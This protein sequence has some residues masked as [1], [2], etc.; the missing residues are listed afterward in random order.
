[1]IWT[2]EAIGDAPHDRSRHPERADEGLSPAE[3]AVETLHLPSRAAKVLALERYWTPGCTAR[4]L[5]RADE[6]VER[7]IHADAEPSDPDGTLE[8]ARIGTRLAQLLPS[9]PERRQLLVRSLAILASA[10]HARGLRLEARASVRSALEIAARTR[11]DPCILGDLQRR[12]SVLL[13]AF[14]R[15]DD[16]LAAADQAVR[17]VEAEAPACR[18]MDWSH[19]LGRVLLDR[20]RLRLRLH[21]AAEALDDAGLALEALDPARHGAEVERCLDLLSL[22]LESSGRPELLHGLGRRLG[23][24]RERIDRG[25]PALRP[26]SARVH[27]LEGRLFLRTGSKSRAERSLRHARREVRSLGRRRGLLVVSLELARLLARDERREELRR[28]SRDT[29]GHFEGEGLGGAQVAE[30]LA[31]RRWR[32]ALA[33]DHLDLEVLGQIAAALDEEVTRAGPAVPFPEPAVAVPYL[34]AS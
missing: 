21:R 17:L 14:G 11:I 20:G 9:S 10:Q 30:S 32:R 18:Q 1:M 33:A 34:A 28:L 13:A 24:L 5:R 2:F 16:A 31:I 4:Y 8:V 23:A 27:R 25:G 12:H 6:L 29:L 15:H 7:Q 26:L 19:C 3:R 22:L